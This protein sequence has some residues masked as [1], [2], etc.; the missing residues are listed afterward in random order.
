MRTLVTG[1]NGFL[2]SVLVERLLDRRTGVG[3]DPVRCFVRPGSCGKLERI[4]SGYPRGSIQYVYGNL[5]SRRSCDE[6]VAGVDV[7]LHLAAGMRGSAA[8][9][10]M[11]TVVTSRNLLDAAVAAGVRRIVLV[12]SFAVYGAD[13]LRRRGMVDEN[14]PLEAHPEWRD[15]YAYAKLR[16]ER[17]FHE[18]QQRYG[19]ELIVMR[20]GVIYGPGG[21][22]FSAR[23]GIQLPGIFLHCGNRNLLPLT[24]VE[25]CADAIAIAAEA[26]QP[27]ANEIYN[28]VDDDLPTSKSYLRDY[29]KSV[30]PLRTISIPYPVTLALS[31]VCEWYSRKSQGQLP[32]ILTPYKSAFQWK[33]FRFTN[34]RLKGIGWR[35]RVSTKDGMRRTFEA[36]RA[37][38]Q[39]LARTSA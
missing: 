11:N 29:R 33:G 10:V 16:Q 35:P 18:Y 34:A 21:G 31:R 30:R 7:V 13:K 17:L 3:A 39:A 9:M 37:Q 25:N 14:A 4:A 22:E 23:V 8:D 38:R 5:T 20:P 12:S 27:S 28:V 15:P 1:A 19:F 2:G 6:A 24:Y 36:F 26:P 32:P